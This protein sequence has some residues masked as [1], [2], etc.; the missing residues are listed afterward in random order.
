M[1][2]HL[3][4]AYFEPILLYIGISKSISIRYRNEVNI[5]IDHHT[6]LKYSPTVDLSQSYNV[7]QRSRSHHGSY[8][9]RHDSR[10]HPRDLSRV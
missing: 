8:G 4:N 1:R 6:L 2:R 10:Y 5:L 7:D 9:N 3:N